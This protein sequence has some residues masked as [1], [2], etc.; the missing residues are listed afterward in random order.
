MARGRSNFEYLLKH[1]TPADLAELDVLI[2]ALVTGVEE[3]APRCALCAGPEPCPHVGRAI[4][5]VLD[6]RA[7]RLLLTQAERLREHQRRLHER[8]T[9]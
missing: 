5:E 7:A 1:F 6:W 3:H 9:A 2:W 8:I 4:Q